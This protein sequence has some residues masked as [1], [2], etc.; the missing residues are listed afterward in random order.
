MTKLGRVAFVALAA[1]GHQGL[2]VRTAG[3]DGPHRRP[4]DVDESRRG[5][6]HDHLGHGRVQLHRAQPRRDLH[7]DLHTARALRVLLRAA[8]ADASRRGGPLTIQR[9]EDEMDRMD[10]RGFLECAAWTGAAVLWTASGGVLSSRPVAE[11]AEAPAGA[12]S[13]VQIS[14]THVG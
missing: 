8:P 11:A 1:L 5:A 13:V 6:A 7:A 14:D 9:A 10:R 2:Q 3:A 12:F 4:G